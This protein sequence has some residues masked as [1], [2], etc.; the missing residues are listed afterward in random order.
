[1]NVFILNSGRCGSTTFIKACRHI[2]NYTAAHESNAKQPGPD[3]LI[4]PDNHIEADNRLTW[5]LGRLDRQ[6]ANNAIYIHLKRNTDNTVKSFMKRSDFG[7]MKAYREGIYMTNDSD[8][9][10][11]FVEDYI[12]TVNS[13][14]QHFLKNKT[15]TMSFKLEQA[16]QDFMEFWELIQAEGNLQSA[17]DEWDIPYNQ[18]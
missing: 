7:I 5:F 17:L 9:L 14:I 16:K 13:N 12:N 11:T 18:S 3:R 4:Y 10:E 1:M 2:N 8:N 6:Y 15:H